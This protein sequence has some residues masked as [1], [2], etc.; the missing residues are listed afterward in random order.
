MCC[1]GISFSTIPHN[2]LFFLFPSSLFI[3]YCF[4]S[5]FLSSFLVTI[6][7]GYY[8]IILVVDW[9]LI[10]VIL[11]NILLYC[12]RVVASFFLSGCTF[13]FIGCIFL[14]VF[15]L[16][17]TACIFVRFSL[18]FTGLIFLLGFY[19]PSIGC[20][21]LSGLLPRTIFPL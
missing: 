1:N 2:C 6:G 11:I 5:K 18:S 15:P 9:R 17:C 16:S 20:I 14:L 12:Y 13:S 3:Y 10:P 8:Y 21:F 7:N 4:F 19:F